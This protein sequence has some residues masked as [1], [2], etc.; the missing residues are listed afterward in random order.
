MDAERI[1]APQAPQEAAT[2]AYRTYEVRRGAA[3]GLAASET[4]QIAAEVPIALEYNGISHA[5]VLASPSDIE[6][7]AYGFSLPKV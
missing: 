3:N 6:D 2:D 1:P 5:T 7:F 4:D